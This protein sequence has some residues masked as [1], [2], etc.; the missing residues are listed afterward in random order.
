[1]LFPFGRLKLLDD[2][3]TDDDGSNDEVVVVDI[4]PAPIVT[5]VVGL[6][7][8]ISRFYILECFLPNRYPAH[9]A[10]LTF[11][12][13]KHSPRAGMGPEDTDRITLTNEK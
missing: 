9:L 4:V 2:S 6:I 11:V 10:I 8:P 3:E 13:S 7:V 5:I 1:M 12:A